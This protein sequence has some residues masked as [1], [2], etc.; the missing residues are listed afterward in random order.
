V[1]RADFQDLAELRVAEAE[2]LFQNGLFDGAY[3]LAGYSVEAGLK[4]CI[5]KLTN[6]YDFPSKNAQR[7][8]YTHDLE[9]LLKTAGLDKMLA[10]DRNANP[11]LDTYWKIVKGWK[12]E[13][14][15]DS[16]GSK[17]HQIAADFLRAIGDAPDGVLTWIK[18]HW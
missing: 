3:Y 12:E 4:A 11:A 8:C 13:S 6:Q 2:C 7:D 15:Y 1:N 5:A 9:I 17:T 16:R 10:D 14:R 18:K